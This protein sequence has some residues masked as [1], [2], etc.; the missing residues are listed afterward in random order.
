MEL[1]L[2][3]HGIEQGSQREERIEK[4]L[5]EVGL[6]EKAK[7]RLNAPAQPLSGGKQQRLRIA[8]T[9]SYRN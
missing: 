2:R 1:S 4:V 8:R 5:K 3:R 7:D 9:L 6:W